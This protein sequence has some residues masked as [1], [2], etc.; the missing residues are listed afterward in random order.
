MID[1]EPA[2]RR[3]AD[4]V[5]N[6]PEE[7]LSAETPCPAYTVGDLVE[8]GG[9]GRLLDALSS[10]AVIEVPLVDVVGAFDD[11]R[12]ALLLPVGVDVAVR[13]DPVQP[14][15]QV[16]PLLEP[17]EPAVGAQVGLLNQVLGIGGV[18]REPH[19]RAVEGR[20]HRQDIALEPLPEP[21]ILGCGRGLGHRDQPIGTPPQPARAG[22]CLSFG[23]LGAKMERDARQRQ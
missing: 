21:W 1:L 9:L 14:R 19:R 6:L 5:S 2:A 8:H 20:Q 18:A 3:T 12:L 22:G 16:R 11:L 15:L 10:E 13:Q 4:L 7:S 23:P 17:R